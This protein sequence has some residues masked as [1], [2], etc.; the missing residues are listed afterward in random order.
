MAGGRAER[1][2]LAWRVPH[3]PSSLTLPP[4]APV[5]QAIS[6]VRSSRR[7]APRGRGAV[8]TRGACQ[9]PWQGQCACLSLRSR[10]GTGGNRQR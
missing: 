7:E 8:V 1:G 2:A 4:P 6:E 10:P 3:G 9:P 5:R